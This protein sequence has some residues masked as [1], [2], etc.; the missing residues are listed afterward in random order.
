[1]MSSGVTRHRALPRFPFCLQMDIVPK[2]KLWF[3]NDQTSLHLM[4]VF[5]KGSFGFLNLCH[6]MCTGVYEHK[7][8]QRHPHIHMQQAVIPKRGIVSGSDMYFQIIQADG[9]SRDALKTVVFSN[10]FCRISSF[11]AL[12]STLWED[13]GL[14]TRN[15]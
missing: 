4:R 3:S 15:C 8:L 1:M 11:L 6:F 14:Q 5:A 10:I 12:K 2:N 7:Q 13:T 9:W